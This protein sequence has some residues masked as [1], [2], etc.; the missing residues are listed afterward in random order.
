MININKL[1]C[2]TIPQA[3][4]LANMSTYKIRKAIKDGK[5]MA[6]RCGSLFHIT[7]EDLDIYLQEQGK[8]TGE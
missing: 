3:A 6:Y 4:Q 7:R 2:L 5:L 8:I 1:G